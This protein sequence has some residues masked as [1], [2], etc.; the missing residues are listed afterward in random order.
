LAERFWAIP[1][2]ASG[3]VDSPAGAFQISAAEPFPEP[4]MLRS[5]RPGDRWGSKRMKTLFQE[6]R[7][8]LWERRDW[9]VLE[10]AGRIVWTRRFGHVAPD[11]SFRIID[12]G[13][14]LNP[15]NSGYNEAST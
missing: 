7:I 14:S 1:V 6:S 13:Q 5:W 15:A 2:T 3:R 9:P 10:S 11:N 12:L 8:P 4:M